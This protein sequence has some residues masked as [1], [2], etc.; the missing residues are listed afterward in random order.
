MSLAVVGSIALD[1]VINPF[2]K[3]VDVLGGSGTYF[4][5]AAS[6]FNR[7]K[8][9]GVVGKDFPAKHLQSMKKRNIDLEGLTTADGLTFRWTGEYKFDMNIRETKKLNLGVFADFKPRLP[10]S[11][12]KAKYLFLGNIHPALQLDV[13]K[14]M[15]ARP[16][17][18]ACDTIDFYIKTDYNNLLKVLKNVD[19]CFFN[20]SEAR[21]ISGE[22]NLFK[23]GKKILKL[24][25]RMVVIKKGEHGCI[26]ISD[27]WHFLAPAYPLESVFDP[28]G[29]GD[30]F[31]GGFMGYISSV[32]KIN[33]EEIKRALIFG[34]VTAS[35]CVED[36]SID[37]FL[38]LNMAKVNE[39][40]RDIKKFT[41]FEAF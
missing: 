13:L 20:D 36:F 7:V 25:P 26:I 17:I 37:R 38:T 18:V 8:L 30:C 32:N 15:K 21:E 12:K 41:H 1:T 31:A 19:I 22:S 6:Y 23:A 29:A 35:Y 24:G 9:V 11:Y 5:Y 2:K 10:E 16:K 28:T 4:S 33:E 40:F 14:Q 3:A 34:T 27:S 39:R